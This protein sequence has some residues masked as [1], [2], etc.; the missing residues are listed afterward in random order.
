MVDPK[1]TTPNAGGEPGEGNQPETPADIK[2]MTDDVNPRRRTIADIVA[3]RRKALETELNEDVPEDQRI[4]FGGD[5]DP[6][7][8]EPQTPPPDDAG[9]GEPPAGAG[10]PPPVPAGQG[11]G[12]PGGGQPEPKVPPVEPMAKIT[13]EDGREVEVPVSRITT[14]VKL[15]GVEKQVTGN[16]LA[17]GFQ[18]AST[19][20]ARFR[21]ANRLW[22]EAQRLREQTPAPQPQQQPA[23]GQ[24]KEGAD[25]AADDE[26]EDAEYLKLIETIQFGEPQEA[27]KALKE[28]D[29]RRG[30]ATTAVDPERIIEE[31]TK[32]TLVV[33]EAQR[34]LNEDL[35][36][37]GSEYPG[38]FKDRTLMQEA[39]KAANALRAHHLTE[40][41][42][43]LSR[44]TPQQVVNLYNAEQA[45]GTVPQQRQIFLDAAEQTA[46][47]VE[48]LGGTIERRSAQDVPPPPPNPGN[49]TPPGPRTFEQKA[50]DK[51]GS[52]TP[53]TPS[54]GTRH[55]P[56]PA[57]QPQT[58]RDIVAE[59]RK[60]RGQA[61]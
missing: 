2:S 25:P 18:M 34:Q 51:R 17:T 26:N 45:K 53:P 16:E 3:S 50:Q 9:S 29:R 59:M 23:D 28:L 49:P 41:G 4:A 21:E 6:S 5:P 52:M 19:S 14:T 7:G 35:T 39:A 20:Q 47:W 58:G 46:K 36:F 10:D 56:P 60:Q 8:D 43:D 40:L 57:A 33:S 37:V 24:P 1:G 13:L 31:V 44:A 22:Q 11:S 61:I 15:D 42:Y 12:E 55:A 54:A 27:A 32:R 30:A 38:V 48:S